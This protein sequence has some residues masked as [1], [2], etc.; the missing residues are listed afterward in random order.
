M[1]DDV[2]VVGGGPVGLV[3]ALH[4]HR[5]GLAVR[6]LERR[7][8]PIDKACGEGLMPTA[9]RALDELGVR[10][11]GRP[12]RGIRYCDRRHQVD[13]DFRAAPG[14]GVRRTV[15]QAGLDQAVRSR[16][17]PIEQVAV[18]TVEQTVDGVMAAGRT[19]RYLVAADGLHSGI[20]RQL[21]LTASSARRARWGQRRHYD[22]TPWSD[23]VEVHWSPV[24]EAYVTPVAENLLGVALL[25]S[26]RRPFAEL[27]AG[28]PS[29]QARL[30][31]AVAT[32]VRGAGPLR[33]QARARVT[34]RV[35]LA[36]DA[37]GYVDALTGEGL[38]IGFAG[39]AR[40]AACLRADRP[41]Q[42]ERDWRVTTRDYRRLTEG[43][44]FAAERPALRRILV[45][46]AAR[47]PWLYR[48]VV[49]R[50]AG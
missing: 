1:T 49:H 29:L 23:R 17:I 34:G 43:L 24:A 46:A 35:L 31:G 14:L 40:L 25:S 16:G 30:D 33:Q 38:A 8:T 47:A 5:V 12:F 18:D 48:Q 3:T 4:L 42:W 6:V 20:R 44:V 2:L 39:A 37:A 41:E 26:S 45:P 15:L 36:G 21:G 27:L 22:L 9:V 11:A 32:A 28:I 50:L 7:A 13:A 10:P 19:A